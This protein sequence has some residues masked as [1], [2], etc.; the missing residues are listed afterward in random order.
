MND[1]LGQ[2]ILAPL[3]AIETR[4]ST[5]ET[6][7]APMQARHGSTPWITKFQR[8]MASHR[9]LPAGPGGKI[10]LS[11][12]PRRASGFDFLRKFLARP[13]TPSFGRDAAAE[14]V[15]YALRCRVAA[16]R[17][18]CPDMSSCRPGQRRQKVSRRYLSGPYSAA[19]ESSRRRII[20]LLVFSGFMPSS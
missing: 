13:T 14:R 5:I 9:H 10:T 15:G 18:G 7:L 20:A 16:K 19:T 1:E 17:I 12:S 3:T 2:Q 8:R 4:I 6:K 11:S